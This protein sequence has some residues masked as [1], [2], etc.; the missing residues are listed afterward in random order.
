MTLQS[1]L[2]DYFLDAKFL[3]TIHIEAVNV[4]QLEEESSRFHRSLNVAG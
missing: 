2:V 1:G 4:T 3:K